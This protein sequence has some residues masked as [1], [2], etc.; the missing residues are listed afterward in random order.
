M[1]NSL[2]TSQNAW[3]MLF[4]AKEQ[5]WAASSCKAQANSVRKI[6]SFLRSAN[7]PPCELA[8]ISLATRKSAHLLLCL[9]CDHLHLLSHLQLGKSPTCSSDRLLTSRVAGWV[10]GCAVVWGGVITSCGSWHRDYTALLRYETFPCTCTPTW[11]YAIRSSAG[12][13][14]RVGWGWVGVINVLRP[15]AQGLFATHCYAR[16]SSLAIA[17]RHDAT[18]SDLLLH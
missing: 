8:N 5:L 7:G 6:L 9:T 2:R 18:L 1:W 11:C 16:R 15:L 12:F 13:G 3:W 14:V 10:G 4:G 17:H